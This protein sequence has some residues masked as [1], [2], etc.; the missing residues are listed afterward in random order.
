MYSRKSGFWPVLQA[1][2][3]VF[4]T[5]V[6]DGD[7]IPE[8]VR[9]HFR[10]PEG[11]FSAQAEVYRTYHMTDVNVFYNKEDQWQIPGQRQGQHQAGIED[12]PAVQPILL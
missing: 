7:K 10:Y 11:L 4:P 3:G 5:L 12:L 6:V 9:E 1:W 2:R 8:A